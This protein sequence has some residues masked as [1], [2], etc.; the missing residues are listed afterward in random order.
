MS[1][2]RFTDCD[3]WRDAWFRRLSSNVKLLW[4]YLCDSCDNAGVWEID[5][6]L[7]DFEMGQHVDLN[8]ALVEMTE[9]VV[10]IDGGRKW[11][12][13]KFILFQNPT[14]LTPT[15][16][17]HV[18]I[19]RLLEHHG[20]DASPFL[21]NGNE[22]VG[23][24]L[25]KAPRSLQDKTRPDQT[26]EGECRGGKITTAEILTRLGMPSG[27]KDVS[28]WSGGLNR[29]ARCR[30]AKEAEIFIQWACKQARNADARI[31]HWRHAKPYAEQWDREARAR[32]LN[33]V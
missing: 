21:N 33:T 17:P 23:L 32:V 13:K 12:I 8:D 10:E 9:R 24:G 4:L 20:L 7:A 2:K 3:K 25:A 26:S 22:R 15:V 31:D 14:G 5:Q 29:V 11:W 6:E 1:R 28:E 18:H 27:P 16:S 19:L 30:S